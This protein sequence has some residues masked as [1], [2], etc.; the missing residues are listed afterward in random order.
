MT[1]AICR[2]RNQT[3]IRIHFG[4]M[5]DMPFGQRWNPFSETVPFITL[6]NHPL[7]LCKIETTMHSIDDLISLLIRG[8][9]GVRARSGQSE[10]FHVVEEGPI[11]I[12]S[13]AGIVS[14]LHNQSKL[15]Y[16]NRGRSIDF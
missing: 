4:K 16:L 7:F 11:L 9:D 2:P 8:I 1:C 3:G 10:Q 15:G 6:T 13:Y 14:M 12:E 5:S